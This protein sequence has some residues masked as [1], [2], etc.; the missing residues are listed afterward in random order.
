MDRVQASS[1]T[2][3][4]LTSRGTATMQRIVAGAAMLIRDRGVA[5]VSL[6][7]IRDATSTSKSQLFHYFPDG[8]ADLLL[9]VARYEAEQILADQQPMLADLTTWPKW[10]AWRHRVIEKYEAQGRRCPLSALTSQLGLANPATQAIITDLYD[11]W[12]R[13]LTVGVKALIDAGEIDQN[14]DPGQAASALLAAVTGG[15]TLLQAT[16]RISYLQA[17]LTEALNGLRA[18]RG[19]SRP[20]TQE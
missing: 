3:R 5:N 11:Q 13:Y 6:D 2:D 12:R 7:D 16:G 17:S 1:S 19:R 9:A 20:Q 10:Q 8:K 4:V 14:T 15:A 18:T